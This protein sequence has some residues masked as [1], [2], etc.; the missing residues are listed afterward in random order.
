MVRTLHLSQQTTRDLCSVNYFVKVYTERIPIKLAEIEDIPYPDNLYVL[1]SC[2]D[3]FGRIVEYMG[4]FNVSENMIGVNTQGEVKVWVNDNLSLIR[5]DFG[6]SE[7][8]RRG[9]I[10]KIVDIVDDN[11]DKA[12]EP[13]SLKQF[14][15]RNMKSSSF[16]EAMNLVKEFARTNRTAIPQRFESVMDLICPAVGL[17]DEDFDLSKSNLSCMSFRKSG[18]PRMKAS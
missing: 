12:S 2:L 10:Q 14:V 4:C 13:S 16:E 18:N 8:H 3:G 11:T 17:R 9:M 1:L 7:K 6:F 15:D 5:P